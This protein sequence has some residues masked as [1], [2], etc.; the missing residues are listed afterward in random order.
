V[1]GR[2]DRGRE[3]RGGA[4]WWKDAEIAAA[5]RGL[6]VETTAS[7]TKVGLCQSGYR[8]PLKTASF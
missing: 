1:T 8:R 7:S 5:Q 4:T 6:I 3:E 2:G